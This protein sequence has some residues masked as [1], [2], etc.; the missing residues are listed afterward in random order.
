MS[1]P[2]NQTQPMTAMEA[3]EVLDEAGLYNDPNHHPVFNDI[4]IDLST[5]TRN[6]GSVMAAVNDAIRKAASELPGQ[7]VEITKATKTLINEIRTTVMSGGYDDG[8]AYLLK[9]VNIVV[10]DDD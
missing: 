8:M 9:W 5:L 10:E 1:Q 2:T 7:G 6:I 3:L 4:S